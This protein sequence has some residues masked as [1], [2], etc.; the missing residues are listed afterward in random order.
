MVISGYFWLFLVISGYFSWRRRRSAGWQ[1]SRRGSLSE[2]ERW[3]I[4]CDSP[5]KLYEDTQ[6]ISWIR[7]VWVIHCDSPYK[8]YEDTQ[9]IYMLEREVREREPSLA[10]AWAITVL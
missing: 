8:L 2:S 7:R 4:H 5:Y 10:T 3:V 9:W 6:W 1:R